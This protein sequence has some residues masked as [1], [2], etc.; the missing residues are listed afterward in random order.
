MRKG[1]VVLQD[2]VMSRM[3]RKTTR[4]HDETNDASTGKVLQKNLRDVR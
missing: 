2:I 1:S 3:E 4:P